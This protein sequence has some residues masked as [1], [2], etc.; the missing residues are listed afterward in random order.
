[1]FI[2]SINFK[3]QMNQS[4]PSPLPKLSL[5][6]FLTINNICF[7]VC[8]FSY[9]QIPQSNQMSQCYSFVNCNI[10]FNN[11]HFISFLQITILASLFIT[12]I[13]QIRHRYLANCFINVSESIYP[14]YV[15][16]CLLIVNSIDISMFIPTV[17]RKTVTLMLTT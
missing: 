7:I 13:E 5:S 14:Q 10:I 11:F 2:F 16:K 12:T 8:S 9:Q 3:L 17:E 15:P 1:M 6:I 4:H